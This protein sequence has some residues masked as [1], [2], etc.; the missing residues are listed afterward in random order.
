M[1]LGTDF[2]GIRGRLIGMI[3]GITIPSIIFRFIGRSAPGKNYARPSIE[4]CAVSLNSCG[5][6]DPACHRLPTTADINRLRN[7]IAIGFDRRLVS[8]GIVGFRGTA[9]A[10]SDHLLQPSRAASGAGR[11]RSDL[12]DGSQRSVAAGHRPESAAAADYRLYLPRYFSVRGKL[13]RTPCLSN[14]SLGAEDHRLGRRL[15]AR[16]IQTRP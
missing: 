3:L 1:L 4:C 6:R 8:D 13:S 15:C 9:F 7:G 10:L 11:K 12:G 2:A 5:C 16:H 14:K